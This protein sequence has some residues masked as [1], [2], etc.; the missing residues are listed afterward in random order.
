M[1]YSTV[2]FNTLGGVYVFDISMFRVTSVNKIL[3]EFFYLYWYFSGFE[4]FNEIEL[5]YISLLIIYF[6]VNPFWCNWNIGLLNIFQAKGE[7]SLLN[8]VF[9]LE[10]NIRHFLDRWTFRVWKFWI[11]FGKWK[12][13]WIIFKQ[14]WFRQVLKFL[15]FLITNIK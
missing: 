3:T 11:W 10:S 6:L 7:I 13:K 15:I 5:M 4:Y 14:L 1:P 9:I 2:N 12:Q 8:L